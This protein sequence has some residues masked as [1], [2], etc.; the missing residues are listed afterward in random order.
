M[1]VYSIGLST[2]SHLHDMANIISFAQ[3]AISVAVADLSTLWSYLKLIIIIPRLISVNGLVLNP[4]ASSFYFTFTVPYH[5]SAHFVKTQLYNR[6]S[7]WAGFRHVREISDIEIWRVPRI[8]GGEIP[9][10]DERLR[11][12][13]GMHGAVAGRYLEAF[14]ELV[15][16]GVRME[17]GETLEEE[18]EAV[19]DVILI[20]PGSER[21]PPLPFGA[22]NRLMSTFI[23]RADIG[24]DTGELYDLFYDVRPP[25]LLDAHTAD[26]LDELT[27]YN[28]LHFNL[29]GLKNILHPILR[30]PSP[31]RVQIAITHLH[32]ADTK[33]FRTLLINHP[34]HKT[35][36]SSG[37]IILKLPLT[38]SSRSLLECN[39]TA[40]RFVARY[41]SVHVPK[42]Y[43]YT[44]SDD[45]PLGAAYALIEGLVGTDLQTALLHLPLAEQAIGSLYQDG[46]RKWHIG[47]IIQ[48][49]L[50]EPPRTWS[51]L[52][53][54]RGER[55][56]WTST[57]AYYLS[58]LK[59][60]TRWSKQSRKL[61]DTT[62]RSED[63][64]ALS[65]LLPVLLGKI[66]KKFWKLTLCFP[67]QRDSEGFVIVRPLFHN[68]VFDLTDGALE[69]IIGGNH[70]WVEA[71]ID[72]YCILFRR[73]FGH[74]EA[75]CTP[76]ERVLRLGRDLVAIQREW[77]LWQFDVENFGWRNKAEMKGAWKRGERDGMGE[78]LGLGLV[79]FGEEKLSRNV[80]GGVST[81]CQ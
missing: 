68:T 32:A 37:K 40:L 38:K 14:T 12:I 41:A 22:K 77:E 21:I 78:L 31:T 35:S 44:L 6:H 11:E 60:F 75:D 52:G 48:K 17:D 54:R 76:P 2:H 39:L 10:L 62:E 80:V 36:S 23:P 20:V 73:L 18:Q 3:T 79:G 24:V 74:L 55:G 9:E 43:G 50:L 7:E 28:Y 67:Y 15:L 56:P 81:V 72:P 42:I 8:E 53:L 49:S 65:Q 63:I 59:T 71:R 66:D 34:Q 64:E 27:T 58:L 46:P 33:H 26:E 47:P 61:Q 51:G 16:K 69:E 29:R 25:W 13:F 19:V 4:I 70:L 30:T 5:S 45:N 1:H 57:E